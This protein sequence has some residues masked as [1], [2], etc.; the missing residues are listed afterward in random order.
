MSTP[1]P[2][3]TPNFHHDYSV[4][5]SHPISQ[6]FPILGTSE[7]HERVCRLSE[8]CSGFE[9]LQTDTVTI[10]QSLALS[11]IHARTLPSSPLEEQNVFDV[12]PTRKLPRQFFK[13]QETV[14][15]L[16]GL[17]HSEVHL[18]GT[19][20]WDKDVKTALYESQTEQGIQV[21][22]LRKMEV[23]EGSKTKVTERLEGVCSK[24]LRPIVQKEAAK[25]HAAHMES[26][27]TLF[28]E[29]KP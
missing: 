3:F 19:L 15:V 12:G 24:L 13:L 5:L 18:T 1:A 11:D 10:P 16:F 6:V 23:V 8:L 7:G 9:L 20:T 21:W 28:G 27:H 4:I 14:P 29:A 17:I 26:Y 2:A 22:K 25:G